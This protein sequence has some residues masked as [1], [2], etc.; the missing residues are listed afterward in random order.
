MNPLGVIVGVDGDIAQVGMYNMS[1]ETEYLWD[2]K[3]LAGPKVGA[4]L[5]VKQNDIKIIAI[6]TSEKI[7]DQQNTVKSA[8]FDNRYSPNSINRIVCL[9]TQGVIDNGK[10][11]L[12]SE[13]VP[14]IGNEVMLTSP[15]DLNSIYDIED[16]EPTISI[17]KSVREKQTVK[18]P[19]NKFFASHIGIFGNT[20]SGKSNTLHK[21]YLE[22]FR[23][24]YR[25]N[26][27]EKSKF[28]VI[29]FNG[30]YT[31]AEQFGVRDQYKKIFDIN[32]RS[33]ASDKLPII[34]DYLFDPD[35]LAILFDARPATQIPFLRSAMK[36]FKKINSAED[37]FKEEWGLLKK[38]ILDFKVVNYEPI[39]QWIQVAK[40]YGMGNDL[41]DWITFG[42]K[43]HKFAELSVYSVDSSNPIITEG[44]FNYKNKI[45]NERIRDLEVKMINGFNKLNELEKLK[46]FLEFQK[47][48]VTA[49]R[50][51]NIEYINPLFKRID[52]SLNSLIPII[53]LTN[54]KDI[55]NKFKC[56]NIIN[57]VNANQEIKR[58]VPMMLSKMIYDRQKEEISQNSKIVKTCH[59]IIDEAH[60]ILSSE[61]RRN[62]DSWQDFRLSVFEEI[63]KEGRKFGFFLTLASQRPADI[64]PTIISQLHNFFIHRLVNENDLHMLENTMP[65][66]DRNSYN[67]IS[68]LGQGEAIITGNAMRVPVIVKVSKEK[69]NRPKSDDIVLT[70]LW[71]N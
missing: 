64:S 65:T 40:S 43:P 70:D 8:Q 44:Q 12:T 37:F 45:I 61:F 23:S 9:K 3:L 66:L 18:L 22:L 58:L 71:G 35:I 53:E 28:F 33:N 14:M 46:V 17:G 41:L 42:N 47:I 62:G 49:W 16:G 50:S 20:G 52:A 68:S 54:N 51:T 48:Y 63:I 21:L 25:N 39:D 15:E 4:F 5:T 31:Q 1:N 13:H 2:G 67:D 59:L 38:L 29:D 19:I 32:T 6:V 7:I 36:E 57:L 26:I 60:N 55:D 24:Q 11:Q 27:F 30:E 56:L 69:Y 34:K 10:F